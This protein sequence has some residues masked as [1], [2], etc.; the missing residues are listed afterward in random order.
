MNRALDEH[1][2][3]RMNALA[4]LPPSAPPEPWRKVGTL[5]VG[6]L[7]EV[8][9]G[10]STDLLL[11]I[12]GAG[13]G[14]VDGH[15]GRLIARD[16][17]DDLFFDAGNLLAEGIGPLAGVKVRVAGLRGGGLS[18]NTSDGW[19]LERLPRAWPD[20]ELIL[21]PP[22]Q[23]ML[24]T[25]RDQP[26]KLIKLAG[27]ISEVCAFGFSPTGKVFIV[28]TASDLAIFSR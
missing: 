11:V 15:T 5:P 13:R 28:A 9:F 26:V 14:V 4:A 2:R 6:G 25:P 17:S 7:T 18:T 23:T 12:S 19:G 27:F 20:D 10:D 1:L 16:D 3:V 8:G 24:W 21:S 22:G